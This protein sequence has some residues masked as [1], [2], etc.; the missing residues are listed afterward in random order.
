MEK[1][2]AFVTG[3]LFGVPVYVYILAAVVLLALFGVNDGV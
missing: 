2:K 3:K 1:V